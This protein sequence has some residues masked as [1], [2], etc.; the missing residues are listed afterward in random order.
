[1]IGVRIVQRSVGRAPL[2]SVIALV[3]AATVLLLDQITKSIAIEQLLTGSRG[4]VGPFRFRLMAN[5]GV[6]MGLPAPTW[7]VFVAVAVLC[8]AAIRAVAADSGWAASV[9]WAVLVGGASGNL[10]DR[11]QHRPRFPDHAVVDWI[12]S[13]SLPTFNLA[14]VAIVVGVVSL[15]MAGDTVGTAGRQAGLASVTS[16]SD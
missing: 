8:V 2:R 4:G 6:L 7:L 3:V 15:M 14:D 13:S 1:M 5:R 11:L 12:A 9:G 10:V 16:R